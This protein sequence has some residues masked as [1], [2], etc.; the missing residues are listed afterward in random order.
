[1]VAPGPRFAAIARRWIGAVSIVV[2]IDAEIPSLGIPVKYVTFG[3]IDCLAGLDLI[4][5]VDEES[6]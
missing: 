5:V 6:P 3:I 2:E 1:M 4:S